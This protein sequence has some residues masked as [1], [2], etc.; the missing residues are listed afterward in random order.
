MKA[1]T[2]ISTLVW[3]AATAVACSA[4]PPPNWAQG[5]A[6]VTLG[7]ASWDR[8]DD[9][10]EINPDGTITEDG[11]VIF[12]IDQVG[13]VYHEDG[14]PIAI[15]LPDGHLVG[16][17]AV[18][19]GE[20]GPMSAAF[21]GAAFAWLSLNPQGHVIRYDRDGGEYYDGTWKGCDGPMMRT[22][23]LVT[24]VVAMREW[25]RRPRVGVGVGVMV[26]LN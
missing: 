20:V 24:H 8:D 13:R 6:P 25:Q 4:T 1:L 15:L 23:T 22:C 10:F 26:P 3:I 17:D 2:T 9:I 5:G 19:M 16:E 14:D 11:D 18:G 21:P 7:H 12:Q